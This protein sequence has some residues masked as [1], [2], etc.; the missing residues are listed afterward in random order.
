MYCYLVI[1][2]HL[3]CWCPLIDQLIIYNSSPVF[4]K[5]LLE[6]FP[7][8]LLRNGQKVSKWPIQE[9]RVPGGAANLFGDPELVLYLVDGRVFCR[10]AS[11]FVRPPVIARA[12]E[13]SAVPVVASHARGRVS[14]TV[15]VY[16]SK[17]KKF[18]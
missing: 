2:W 8:D 5:T 18:I 14:A 12:T 16:I 4:N 13:A 17:A 6:I 1:K 3:V 7:H 9:R 15:T 11:L 10:P